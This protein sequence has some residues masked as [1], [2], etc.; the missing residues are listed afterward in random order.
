MNLFFFLNQL[1]QTQSAAVCLKKLALELR[2]RMMNCIKESFS[3]CSIWRETFEKI[4]KVYIPENKPAKNRQSSVTMIKALGQK[5]SSLFFSML[6][7]SSLF[8]G[9]CI[10]PVIS[11]NSDPQ[12]LRSTVCTPSP[13][14]EVKCMQLHYK[15]MQGLL[16]ETKTSAFKKPANH[17]LEASTKLGF[18]V[19]FS[20]CYHWTRFMK[21]LTF[22]DDGV[23]WF[24]CI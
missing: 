9:R 20:E 24:C 11:K 23:F 5:M 19:P 12:A 22:S 10:E 14:G 6:C 8:I 16:E 7:F 21:C 15:Y 13:P 18:P 1:S 2:V 4:N 3:V 17:N